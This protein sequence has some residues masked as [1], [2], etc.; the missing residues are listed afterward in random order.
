M[1]DTQIQGPP[2]TVLLKAANQRLRELL[3]R[4]EALGPEEVEHRRTAILR[5][6][7]I[8]IDLEEA[9]LY[10]ALLAWDCAS[11][12]KVVDQA[13]EGHRSLKEFL[14]EEGT[15]ELTEIRRLVVEHLQLE[16]EQVFPHVRR[17]PF[18]DQWK[19]SRDLER[20]RA[21]LEDR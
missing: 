7:G 13:L 9:L 12:R 4:V 18:E 16:E 11:A 19:L 8:H 10:P 14:G 21:H 6:L 2:P 3:E 17:L 5:A 15:D 20:L 1:S